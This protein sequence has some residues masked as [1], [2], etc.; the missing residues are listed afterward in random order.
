MPE[1][2]EVE[3]TRLGITPH[4]LNQPIAKVIVR[5]AKLRWPIPV[6]LAAHLVKQTIISI[7][8]RGKYLLIG[9]TNGTLIIHL[10]MSGS[11]RIVPS[12]TEPGKHD[13]LDISL[14]NGKCLRLRDPRRF[15]AIL[16]KKSDPLQHKLLIKLGVE[17]LSAQFTTEYL[18]KVA[19]HRKIAIKQF[20]MNSHIVVGV[21]NIY[22]NEALFLAGIRPTIAA[23]RI[24]RQRTGLLVVAIKEVLSKAIKAGGTTLKDFAA[25]DG[26]PGYFQQ[27]LN[28]YNRSNEPCHQC[29]AA[30]I[31]RQ[32]NQRASYYCR[33]CQT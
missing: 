30:I 4:L 21:G 9:T 28:V 2:P 26:Q 5:Q 10:G 18:Y 13:H 22:A 25:S 1:L 8:R 31:M 6:S 14:T 27:Q 33:C 11:L 29:G 20:V 7:D 16:W 17:P 19:R 24:N 32:Q 12:A 3:T 15:G 23:G